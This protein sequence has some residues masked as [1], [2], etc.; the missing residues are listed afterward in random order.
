MHTST[1]ILFN[2]TYLNYFADETEN[3]SNSNSSERMRGIMQ[4][5][6]QTQMRKKKTASKNIKKHNGGDIKGNISAA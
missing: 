3:D 2:T 4:N 5:F 1:T 6:Y